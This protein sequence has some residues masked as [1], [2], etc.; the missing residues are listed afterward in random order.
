MKKLRIFILAVF[1]VVL[2]FVFLWTQQQF[3]WAQI[4][5]F[6]LVPIPERFTELYFNDYSSLPRKTVAKEFIS[7]SFI[8]H[9]LEGATTTYPYSVYFQYPDGYKVVF[10]ADAITLADGQYQT[11][12]ASHTWLAS[13]LQGKVVAELNNLNQHIDFILPNNN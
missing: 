2:L 5:N 11:I 4:K 10:A 13:D 12:I 7:F 1:L 3:V 8:I 6:N 9:N